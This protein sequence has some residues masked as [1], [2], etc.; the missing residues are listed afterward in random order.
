MRE[1]SLLEKA[2]REIPPENGGVKPSRSI[3][4]REGYI[5]PMFPPQCQ[6]KTPQVA[7]E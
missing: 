7:T 6:S 4:N 2:K 1:A 3:A 5:I